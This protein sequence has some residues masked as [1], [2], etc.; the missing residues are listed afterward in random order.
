MALTA[1]F[2]SAGVIEDIHLGV[3]HQTLDSRPLDQ[4]AGSSVLSDGLLTGNITE[5]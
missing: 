2:I 4:T 3:G 1:R 5:D